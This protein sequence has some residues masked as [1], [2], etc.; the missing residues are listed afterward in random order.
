MKEKFKKLLKNYRIWILITFLL[1][2]YFAINYDFTGENEVVINGVSMNSPASLAGISFDP[3]TPLTKLEKILYVNQKKINSIEDYYSA[4]NEIEITNETTIVV[5]TDKN[6]EGYVLKFNS[7]NLDKN[8]TNEELIGIS[9]REKPRSNIRLG[10]ELEGGSRIILKPA[11]KIDSETFDLLISNI[12]DRLDVYGASGV[13]VSKIEDTFTNEK[14]IL[15]E[16]SSSNKEEIYDLINQKG[17]FVAKLGNETVFTGEDVK[18]VMTDAQHSGLESCGQNSDNLIYCTFRFQVEI[19]SEA[20]ERFLE[21]AKKLDVVKGQNGE[22]YLSKKISFLL[23]NKTITELNVASSFKYQKVT[24]PTITVS[25]EPAPKKELAI[26]NGKKE[27]KK[28]QAL[29]S[30]D[31][32]PTDLELVQSYNIS[33]SLGEKLLRN[34][35][36]IGLMAVLVVAFFVGL[37]YRNK[38]IFTSVLI[39]LISELIII[40]GMSAFMKLTIDLAA[41]GGLIAAIGT[42]VDDQIIITDEYFRSKNKN[43]SNKKRIK[44]AFL[45][46][47]LAYITT[48]SAMVPIAFAGLKMLQGFAVT[49]ILGVTIGILITRPAFGAIIETFIDKK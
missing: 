44:K 26:E 28:L 35:I 4:I 18:R 19:S 1:I 45:L 8:K 15:V 27:M 47:T 12:R 16:S 3:N 2:S 11:E 23:D 38:V 32:L 22:D 37:R 17:K 49:I 31:S 5:R 41:I 25:G 14:F 10:I 42:G 46:I 29:L 7:T 6:L 30:T 21:V 20:A 40:L 9:V 24:T 48:V 36:L 33:S 34:A 39:T 43:L 13:K